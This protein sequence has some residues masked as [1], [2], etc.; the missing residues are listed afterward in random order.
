MNRFLLIF[1]IVLAF[2]NNSFSEIS[3][4]GTVQSDQDAFE[5]DFPELKFGWGRIR[6]KKIKFDIGVQGYL[7]QEDGSYGESVSFDVSTKLM[8]KYFEK[9][10]NGVAKRNRGRKYCKK[11]SCR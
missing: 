10:S 4:P 1:S 11:N 8:L 2:S 7:N 3:G 9:T 6:T 5:W